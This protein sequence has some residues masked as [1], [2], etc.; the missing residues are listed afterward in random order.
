MVMPKNSY[1]VV[2]TGVLGFHDTEISEVVVFWHQGS[3]WHEAGSQ[4]SRRQQPG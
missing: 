2:G 4:A 3:V 1:C